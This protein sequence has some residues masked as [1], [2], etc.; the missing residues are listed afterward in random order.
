MQNNGT[1]IIK[2]LG[3]HK[4]VPFLEWFLITESQRKALPSFFIIIFTYLKNNTTK[5]ELI[6]VK[7]LY[8]VIKS[9]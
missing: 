5:L 2:P 6:H 4:Q 8:L 3:G 7:I 9:P 1:K